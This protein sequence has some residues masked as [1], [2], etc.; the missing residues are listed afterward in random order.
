MDPVGENSPDASGQPA[1]SANER[2]NRNPAGKNVAQTPV[3]A[4]AP[5][6]MWAASGII[7]EGKSDSDATFDAAPEYDCAALHEDKQK[8]ESDL[9]RWP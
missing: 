9:H 3:T 6:H 5:N 4:A 2:Q 7:P 8:R 1:S